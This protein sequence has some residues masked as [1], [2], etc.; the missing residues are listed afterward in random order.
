VLRCEVLLICLR[1]DQC[2][3]LDPVWT[4][5]REQIRGKSTTGSGLDDGSD[6][7]IYVPSTGTYIAQ[8]VLIRR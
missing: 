7:S 5:M 6:W 2:D 3:A 1:N 8:H 4:R